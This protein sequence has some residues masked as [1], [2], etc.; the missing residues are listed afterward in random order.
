[1]PPSEEPEPEPLLD[2]TRDS[3]YTVVDNTSDW[4][5]GFF[6]ASDVRGDP[7]A[8]V[9]RGLLAVGG[10]WDERDDFD[11]NVRFRAEVT[12]PALERRLRL[13]AGR[14]DTDDII[15]G[16]ETETISS[17][18]EQ[19]SDFT[20]DDWLLG[21]GYRGKSGARDG[22]DFSVGASIQGGSVDPYV[23]A[24]Y[25][26]NRA[27]ADSWFW[28]L[29]PRVFWQ[30]ERGE[31]ASISSILDF[32]ATENWL[33]RSRVNL[34]NDKI[35]DGMRWKKEFVAYQSLSDD[36]ALSYRVFAI[37]ETDN[38][39]QLLDYGVELRLRQ[40]AFRDWFFVEFSTGVTWPREFL[41]ERRESNIGAGIEF[42]MQFGDW[43]GRKHVLEDEPGN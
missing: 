29:R 34:L 5:D 43:P 39:V 12:L 9:S 38:E 42:E 4:F 23:R 26:V 20:D 33:L 13:L 21:L 15:D 37:G 36:R 31:G 19:F 22:F 27:W 6:G 40:R 14:G 1:M 30:E 18:P 3:V 17:L 35:T 25:R 41:I 24:T 8:E 10:R 32:V 28:R 2:R 7:D 16:S 11:S